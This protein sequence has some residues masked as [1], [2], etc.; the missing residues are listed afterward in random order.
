ML[1]LAGCT[2]TVG[3]PGGGG[4]AAGIAACG[5]PQPFDEAVFAALT[6]AGWDQSCGGGPLPGTCNHMKLSADG[7]FEWTA[8]SDVVE[9]DQRGV[10]NFSARTETEG[11]VCLDTGAVLPFK[12]ENGALS[13]G[14]LGG[15]TP[16]QPLAGTGSRDDLWRVLSDPIYASISAHPWT[17]TNNFDLFM[18]A[19]DFTLARDGTYQA[20]YRDGTC[21]HGGTWGIDLEPRSMGAVPVLID[22]PD[23][24]NCDLR[25][26]TNAQL[27]S[28]DVPRID[29]GRLIMY[30]STYRGPSA[31]DTRLFFNFDGY[32]DEVSTSG[33]LDQ[34]LSASSPTTFDF[35]LEN[36]SDTA[37][38]LV[39]LTARMT[40]V[41]LVADGYS[42]AGPKV[43]LATTSLAGTVIGPGEHYTLSL[44]VTPT[45]S[46]DALFELE[47]DFADST[48]PFNSRGDYI[49]TIGP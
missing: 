43:D 35:D 29:Q 39:S 19:Q 46:G 32:S 33:Y 6:Q 38:S 25:G 4:G 42:S 24:N 36:R 21:T 27:P 40:P 26:G 15:L 10:W 41:M 37:K 5:D 28:V 18:E 45:T 7:S 34:E 23:G 49:V 9:R 1:V 13:I 8:I 22:I 11:I 3:A 14:R 16:G 30:S 20:S 2:S 31:L 48:Q 44:A 17:K 12:L 47:L